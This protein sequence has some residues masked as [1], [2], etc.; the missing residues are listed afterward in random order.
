MKPAGETFALSA[1]ALAD[2]VLVSAVGAP[3]AM[4]FEKVGLDG[5]IEGDRDFTRIVIKDS[6]VSWSDL[7]TAKIK[8]EVTNVKTAPRVALTVESDDKPL[9]PVLERIRK[10]RLGELSPGE[11]TCPSSPGRRRPRSRCPAAR[12]ASPRRSKGSRRSL[13]R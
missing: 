3:P 8:G 4:T 6:R 9:A 5:E 12:S 11:T 7:V 2:S 1:K 13:S 10:F